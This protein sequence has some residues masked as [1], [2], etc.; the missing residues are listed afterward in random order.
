MRNWPHQFI[1][2]NSTVYLSTNENGITEVNYKL[3]QQKQIGP[4][5][6]NSSVDQIVTTNDHMYILSFHNSFKNN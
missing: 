2:D 6:L 1:K 4:K 3:R 5:K